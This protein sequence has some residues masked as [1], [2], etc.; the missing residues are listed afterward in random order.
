MNYFGRMAACS[1]LDVADVADDPAIAPRA[2]SMDARGSDLPGS[3]VGELDDMREV[4][5][6]TEVESAP[7]PADGWARARATPPG[8]GV[9]PSHDTVASPRGQE[10]SHGDPSTAGAAASAVSGADRASPG[11]A[12]TDDAIRAEPARSDHAP[13]SPGAPSPPPAAERP[14]G[15][16][17]DLSETQQADPEAQLTHTLGLV[18]AW[19]RD[20]VPAGDPAASQDDGDAIVQMTAPAGPT[21]ADAD[22]SDA[23]AAPKP[24]VVEIATVAGDRLA[25]RPSSRDEAQI[26]DIATATIGF[27]TPETTV[28]SH[29]R[30]SALAPPALPR[31]REA[32]R[33]REDDPRREPIEVVEV[34]IGTISVSIETP[35]TRD[36]P[37]PPAPA[38]PALAPP[39]SRPAPR[40]ARHYIR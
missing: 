17:T 39:P 23:G 24:A 6:V 10:P 21:H 31:Q 29:E 9:P 27:Q 35:T 18:R 38:A 3:D 33:S 8:A 16:A 5:V 1:E 12:R 26:V 28:A 30:P 36:A 32:A 40:L 15:L 34:S 11:H 2:G 25:A 19:I 13:A 4:D 7:P 22:P 37:A 20:G 14:P